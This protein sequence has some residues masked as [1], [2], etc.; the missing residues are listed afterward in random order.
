MFSEGE[1]EK[2]LMAELEK[3]RKAYEI[4]FLDFK[5]VGTE[6]PSGLP[7]PNGSDRIRIAGAEYRCA[8]EAYSLALKEFNDFLTAWVVPE[9]LREKA[10]AK[11]M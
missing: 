5:V 9:R 2:I 1:I 4:A 7:Q 11:G 10:S 6:F 3:T 8:M